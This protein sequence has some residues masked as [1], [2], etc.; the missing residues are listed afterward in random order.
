MEAKNNEVLNGV[1]TVKSTDETKADN[2][3]KVEL[4]DKGKAV[5]KPGGVLAKLSM[6]FSLVALA[7]AIFNL[8]FGVLSFLFA[9]LVLPP[10]LHAI[11][12]VPILVVAILAIVFASIAKKKGNK[13]GKRKIGNAIGIISTLILSV[14]I[15]VMLFLGIFWTAII[16]LAIVSGGI[17]LTLLEIVLGVLVA[18]SPALAPIL[19]IVGPILIA[20]APIV[21]GAF[22][23]ALAPELVA[24]LLEFIKTLVASGVIFLPFI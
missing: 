11:L 20:V 3:Y 4:I 2:T 8:I 15:I 18:L 16:I 21:I 6:I 13:S 5:K 14:S 22:A 19:A 1:N 24:M 9:I 7:G 12:C 10:I 23:E 17:A